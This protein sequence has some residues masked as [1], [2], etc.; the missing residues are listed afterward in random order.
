VPKQSGDGERAKVSAVV[1]KEVQRLLPSFMLTL[2]RYV[3]ELRAALDASDRQ[4]ITLLAHQLVGIGGSLG[5]EAITE[6]A[7]K[8]QEA[9]RAERPLRD[10]VAVLL[11]VCEG[12]LAA[13]EQPS[14][15]APGPL[16]V[17]RARRASAGRA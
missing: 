13:H 7:R 6:A 8:V 1:H 10:P 14:H 9:A 17:V 15:A 2:R 16:D 4:R 11:A 12:A 3:G 5:F